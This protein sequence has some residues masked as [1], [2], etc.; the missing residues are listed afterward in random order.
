MQRG[1]IYTSLMKDENRTIYKTRNV[2]IPKQPYLVQQTQ[3]QETITHEIPKEYGC[4][5]M[6]PKE[7][8]LTSE[9]HELIVQVD[10]NKNDTT[11]IENKLEEKT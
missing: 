3:R 9:I 7:T 10:S 11:E 8:R 1:Y 6:V 5:N 2:K 4:L